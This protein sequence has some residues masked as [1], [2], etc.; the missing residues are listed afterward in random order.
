MRMWTAGASESSYEKALTTTRDL[1]MRF[2]D[3]V[4]DA[5]ALHACNGLLGSEARTDEPT[6]PGPVTLGLQQWHATPRSSKASSPAPRLFHRICRPGQIIRAGLGAQRN[7]FKELFSSLFVRS[8]QKFTA[9]ARDAGRWPGPVA[10]GIAGAWA[11]GSIGAGIIQ[12]KARSH[13]RSPPESVRSAGR[14]G[15]DCLRPSRWCGAAPAPAC[16]GQG[17]SPARPPENR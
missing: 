3:I 13:A 15:A 1:L 14:S 4:A 8:S 6:S 10:E 9:G 7:L 5:E 2:T 16:P 17:P 11:N 12:Q